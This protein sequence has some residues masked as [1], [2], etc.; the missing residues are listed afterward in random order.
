M[1]QKIVTAIK[2]VQWW[3]SVALLGL[4]ALAVYLI[5]R[6]W[7]RK[8]AVAHVPNPEKVIKDSKKALEKETKENEKDRDIAHSDFAEW[9]RKKR[10]KT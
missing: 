6:E 5:R 2:K 9:M 4:L 1:W 3:I 10:N 7:K 8:P